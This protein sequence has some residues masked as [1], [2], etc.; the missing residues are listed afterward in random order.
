MN[1]YEVLG[2]SDYAVVEDVKKAYK[3]LAKKYHP[4]ANIDVDAS[5]KAAND[6]K[7]KEINDAYSVL[8]DEG[9]KKQY[10]HNLR[11]GF[12]N[13]NNF[14]P[15]EGTGFNFGGFNFTFG[16]MRN[17]TAVIEYRFHIQELR[18]LDVRKE[19]Y[20]SDVTNNKRISDTIDIKMTYDN[21][22]TK[23]IR[24]H[25]AN[26][27]MYVMSQSHI[28]GKGH[29]YNGTR[30]ML[31]LVLLFELP[32]NVIMD[33]RAN[34]I[35]SESVSLHDVVCGDGIELK[36][37]FGNTYKV[38]VNKMSS[39]SDVKCV[40][41]DKGLGFNGTSRRDYVFDLKVNAPDISKL[42]ESEKA[43]LSNLL[44]KCK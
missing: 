3:T 38:K 11:H 26:H 34:I 15:F 28:P 5:T 44:L 30:G 32:S 9:K 10:D 7:M 42:N 43:E 6:V 41:K 35:H 16:N 24:I 23:D 14:N 18:D 17:Q 12:Q 8:S 1:H 40:L 31:E 33:E 19:F 13:P 25:Q 27:R 36:T 20:V 29:S 39:L 2:V 4:D 21:I 37:C 22:I